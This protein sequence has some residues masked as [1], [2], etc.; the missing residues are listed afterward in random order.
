MS[1][2]IIF[3]N[4]EANPQICGDH[5]MTQVVE[6]TLNRTS[7]SFLHW[8]SIISAISAAGWLEMLWSAKLYYRLVTNVLV[9]TEKK[10]WLF[11]R[12]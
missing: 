10:F 1:F 4:M 7:V 12:E 8:F 9:E 2:L 5:H 11:N 6:T 3:S